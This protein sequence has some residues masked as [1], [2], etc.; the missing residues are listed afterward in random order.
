[1]LSNI[2]R[3]YLNMDTRPH[4]SRQ[5]TRTLDLGGSEDSWSN[6]RYLTNEERDEI[7][8]QTKS[9][10][11]TCAN[12]VKELEVLETRTKNSLYSDQRNLKNRRLQVF[13]LVVR[14]SRACH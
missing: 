10:L 11:T 13:C 4:A 2:R 12:R 5:S 9:I 3:P 1:M 6:I 8:Q 7:D 14:Q